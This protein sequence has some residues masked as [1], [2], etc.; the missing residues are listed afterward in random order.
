[1]INKLIANIQDINGVKV[2]NTTPHAITLVD[3][4]LSF[5]VS[6]PSS[7]A[8]VNAKVQTQ[9]VD[10]NIKGVTL[11]TPKFI[12]DT[13]TLTILQQFKHDYPD[14]VVIGSILACQ[15][16]TGLVYGLIAHPDFQ[17]VA[18]ADKKMLYNSYTIY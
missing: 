14:V 16:Y 9:D 8:L 6:V 15:A 17:R 4:S 11:N 2:V 7:G 12:A 13:T 18:P 3:S 10:S 1:M 5:Q